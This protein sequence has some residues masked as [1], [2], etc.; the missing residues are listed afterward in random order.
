LLS[1]KVAR[2]VGVELVDALYEERIQ[3][4][5]SIVVEQHNS[6]GLHGT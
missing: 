5:A 1:I 6:F 4:L 2:R 3:L